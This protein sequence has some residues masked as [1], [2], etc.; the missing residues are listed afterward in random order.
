MKSPSRK[1]MVPE[2]RI[3]LQ[4]RIDMAKDKIK[5]ITG[6]KGKVKDLFAPQ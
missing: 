2:D 3:D 5:S 6:M 1:F 4:R